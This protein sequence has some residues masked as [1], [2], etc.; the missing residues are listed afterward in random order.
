M[1]SVELNRQLHQIQSLIK[2]TADSTNENIE[3]QGHWGK[4]LCVLTAGFLEN[5]ITEVFLS[6]VE[7]SSSPK[8]ASF[9]VRNLQKIQN[10]KSQKFIDVAHSFC[11]EWGEEIEAYFDK[12]PN[13]KTAVDSIM[14]VRHQIAHGKNTSISVIRVSDYLKDCVDLIEFIE[15]LCAEE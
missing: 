15:C 4:Y 1:D 9:A 14:A 8:V 3:L 11:K 2:S 6:F 7:E 5:A 12:K 13:V 10:P